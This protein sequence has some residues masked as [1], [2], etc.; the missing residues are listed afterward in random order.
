MIKDMTKGNPTKLIF[1]FA[2]PMLLGNLVQQLYIMIDA[3]IVGKFVSV[4]ALAAVG[5]TGAINFFMISLIIGLMSGI[6]V[7]VA[8][9]FGFQDYNKLKD[10][11]ATAS[12]A[13]L[14]AGI[15]FTILGLLLAK[16]L[17]ILLQ[18]PENIMDDATVFLTTL[19]IGILPMSLY[20]GV[21]AILRA[22]GN[23]ITPLVFLIFSS[24]MNI[25]LDFVFVV[26]MNYGVQGAAWATVLSQVIAAILCL[27]YAYKHVPYMRIERQ[28]FKIHKP[29]LKE[30][31]RIGLPSGLQ[32]AFIS[33]GNMAIQSLINGFGATVV[34]AYT[35]ASR[36]DSLTYQPG[37]AFGAASSTF[38][39]QNV[40]AGKLDRVKKGFWSG[41]KVV[42]ITSLLITI[43]VQLFAKQFLL[44][45]VDGKEK[46]VIEI[47]MGYLLIVSLFYVVVGIL[48]VVRETL[49]GTGDALVPLMMG[50]FE[51][52]S[53][54]VIGFALSKIMGYEGL[55]WATPVAWV[56]ATALGLWR[57]KSG[58]WKR[59]A[60]IR[61]NNES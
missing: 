20:N 57:Y 14:V 11:I 24:L 30:M 29:L 48:F 59:K 55:W 41:I 44:L 1:Y 17:L 6:A 16:P 45:F 21:S 33:I 7:V 58:A 35:A 3:V 47:G 23:S 13:V 46:E 5:S 37:I 2:M 9:Y 49:R 43:I 18:T 12:I 52:V 4:D 42:T 51:L 50:I 15:V 22:L 26:W 32:G 19:F 56:T 36:I 40:G 31:I 61:K 27:Y 28:R 54:L 10:V 38:A 8:Q 34:A 39:A 53:R 60:V 25:V